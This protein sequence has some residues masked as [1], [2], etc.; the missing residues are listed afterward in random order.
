[1]EVGDRPVRKLLGQLG[2]SLRS[3]DWEGEA[4]GCI[5][6]VELTGFKNVLAIGAR[7]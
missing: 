5:L 1:M 3:L 4:T 2:E 6:K 7:K